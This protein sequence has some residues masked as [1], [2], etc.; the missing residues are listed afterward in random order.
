MA[1]ESGEAADQAREDAPEW[2]T[3]PKCE[4]RASSEARS[5]PGALPEL[6][7][8]ARSGTQNPGVPEQIP[9]LFS[10]APASGA[11]VATP[12]SRRRADVSGR[13]RLS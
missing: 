12:A 13:T 11:G 10:G 5:W 1:D 9:E 4:L 8:R 2:R 7:L 6:Q 3:T